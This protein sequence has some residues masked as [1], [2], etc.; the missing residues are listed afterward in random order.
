MTTSSEHAE[1]SG[2]VH[3]GD[4]SVDIGET[5]DSE[6]VTWDVMDAVYSDADG[7]VSEYPA[8][9][10]PSSTDSNVGTRDTGPVPTCDPERHA[11]PDQNTLD[12]Y[13]FLDRYGKIITIF[14]RWALYILR[15]HARACRTLLH[16]PRKLTQRSP[17]TLRK[18][19]RGNL[20]KQRPR[21]RGRGH[22]LP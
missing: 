19:S 7:D 20:K 6:L 17:R 21:Y 8:R 5:V 11:G 18:R 4:T 16:T 12:T 15:G 9:L 10:R 3:V 22:G 1:G 14:W 13:L 2:E